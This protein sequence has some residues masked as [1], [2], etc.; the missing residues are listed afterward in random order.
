[1]IGSIVSGLVNIAFVEL[2]YERT[3]SKTNFQIDVFIHSKIDYKCVENLI[4]IMC[5]LTSLC[6]S[7]NGWKITP[8]ME[9][10]RRTQWICRNIP[11]QMKTR[12]MRN[13]GDSR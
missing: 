11:K 10:Y 9:K 1:M 2:N 12:Y 8:I 7:L 3:I 6:Y 4:L 13:F 5:M